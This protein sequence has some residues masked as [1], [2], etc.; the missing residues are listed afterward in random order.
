MRAG[1]GVPMANERARQLRSNT[2]DAER[3]LWAHLRMLKSCGFHFRRQV[4][5]DQFIVDFAGFS[6]RLVIEVDG[7]Q[8]GYSENEKRDE[9]RSHYLRKQ[10]FAVV[11]FWNNDVL[12]N[13]E[14]VMHEILRAL[15]V[16]YPHP[17]PSPQGGEA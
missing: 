7:G 6:A 15:R 17:N 5:I 10:G 4:S 2:T 8:H 14:G 9:A 11:R 1:V 13:I 16:E 12:S 3:K